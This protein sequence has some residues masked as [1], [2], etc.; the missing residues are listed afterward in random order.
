MGTII[1]KDRQTL[2]DVAL[3]SSGSVEAAMELAIL[4]GRSL[5]SELIDGDRLTSVEVVDA[6]VV[7]RYSAECISPATEVA[8]EG[9]LTM[10][11]QRIGYMAV[12]V[13]FEVG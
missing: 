9:K 13:D 12:G 7:E 5:T 4:N 6:K 3:E 1:V 2:L 10:S 11:Y 8:V